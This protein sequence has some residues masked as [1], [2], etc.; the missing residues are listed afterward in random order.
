MSRIEKTKCD[1]CG[2]ETVGTLLCHTFG[3]DLT[4][5]K[6]LEELN[7]DL[8]PQCAREWA[9]FEAKREQQLNDFFAGKRVEKIK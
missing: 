7:K 3:S 6:Y 5:W 8:C 2:K 9:E 4:G 1:R